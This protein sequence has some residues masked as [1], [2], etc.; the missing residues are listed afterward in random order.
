MSKAS[1]IIRVAGGI[2]EG[3]AASAS[4]VSESRSSMHLAC[5]GSERA[6]RRA[7]VLVTEIGGAERGLVNAEAVC[8]EALE[9]AL[10]SGKS[11]LVEHDGSSYFLTVQVPT[12]RLVLIGTV[13]VSQAPTPI[14]A[15]ADLDVTIIDSRSAY[16]ASERSPGVPIIVQ[17]PDEGL[18]CA[19]LDRYTAIAL[20]THDP[21][22]DNLEAVRAF[23]RNCFYGALGSRKTHA[24]RIEQMR[25]QGFWGAALAHIHSPIDLDIGAVSPTEIAVSI[26]GTLRKRPLRAEGMAA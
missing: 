12:V 3:S 11:G 13:H 15:I 9:A 23:N 18:D 6:K 25:A 26:I 19:P 10:R 22:I 7:A 14:A 21:N 5:G 1:A 24:R 4:I 8:A 20:L 2:D 16:A 17:W